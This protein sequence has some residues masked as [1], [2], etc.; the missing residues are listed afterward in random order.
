MEEKLNINDETW[1]AC[2]KGDKKAYAFIYRMYY[3]RLY[4]YGCR[5]TRQHNLVEDCIQD[6][7]TNFWVGREKFADVHTFQSYL[8]VSFRNN[9]LRNIG[10]QIKFV[11]KIYSEDT[12][13]F[14]LEISAEKVRID[15]EKM[16]EQKVRLNDVLNKLTDRQKEIIFLKF[17]ANLPY[18]EIA[19]MLGISIKATY[20]LFARAISELR[21]TYQ[22]KLSS[23]LLSITL[24]MLSF[25][26]AA[27]V[28]SNN[29]L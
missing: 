13:N 8:F 21:Q 5:F 24:F 16:Y 23:L 19:D 4:V 26:N 20:K 1:Q 14:E 6:I 25:S 15:T 3:S 17:Y 7:F 18:E 22:K 10:Q 28:I 9:L 11:T 29:F 27:L 2:K 12:H